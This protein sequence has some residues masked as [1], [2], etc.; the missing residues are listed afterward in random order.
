[1]MAVQRSVEIES[2][3]RR[4]LRAWQKRDLETISNLVSTD[5]G[6]RVIGSD[7]DEQWVGPDQ[8]F[9]VFATQ[10]DEMPDWDLEIE[11]VE[12]FEDGDV[13]W[14]VGYSTLSAPE[15]V[16]HARHTGV[17]RIEAGVWRAVHWHN[18]VPVSN[19]ELFGLDLTTTLDELVTSVLNDTKDLQLGSEGTMSLVFTDIVDS[20]ALAAE[21]GDSAWTGLIKSHEE[22]IR[23]I[24]D[25][26]RGT[27]VKFLGD[28]SMLAFESAREAIRAAIEISDSSSES[29]FELRIGIHTGE[30]VR[31]GDD[32]F[33]TTVNKAARVA[34]AAAAGQIMTSSTTRDLAGSM[35]EVTFGQPVNVA[36]KGLPDTHQIV[37]VESVRAGA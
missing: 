11:S 15:R 27:V 24:T 3:A 5:A 23:E 9:A 31:T 29:P 32:L 13:G 22:Q 28:G 33:G 17:F 1:M 21:A 12:G 35:D 34:S 4:V 26:H 20:T 19:A 14:A 37:A 6:L 18:S 8:F 25:S 10:S 36:L 7:S 30:V 2:V 16:I